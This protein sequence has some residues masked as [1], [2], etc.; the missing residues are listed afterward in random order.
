VISRRPDAI[1]DGPT[2]LPPD[3]EALRWF[4]LPPARLTH[5]DRATAG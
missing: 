3:F 4:H 1:D 5:P 2:G